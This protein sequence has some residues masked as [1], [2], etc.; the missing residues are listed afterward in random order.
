MGAPCGEGVLRLADVPV[1]S[2]EVLSCDG[3]GSKGETRAER[4]KV[5]V[6]RWPP[7][8]SPSHSPL[9]APPP[10]SRWHPDK[11]AQRYRQ[12]IP[13]EEF[14]ALPLGVLEGVGVGV[15]EVRIIGPEPVL[16][17]AWMGQGVMARVQHTFQQ[18]QEYKYVVDL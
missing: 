9:P 14:E 15:E 6:R 4:F 8:R 3:G 13:A 11:F 2:P 5:L 1:L 12:A 18:L 10:P 17:P 16:T 7:F